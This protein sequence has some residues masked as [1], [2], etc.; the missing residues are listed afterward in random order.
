MFATPGRGLQVIQAVAAIVEL[1]GV[2]ELAP[3]D[4]LA[5]VARDDDRSRLHPFLGVFKHPCRESGDSVGSAYCAETAGSHYGPLSAVGCEGSRSFHVCAQSQ[6]HRPVS[7]VRVLA[8]IPYCHHVQKRK[9]T[10][11]VLGEI[12]GAQQRDQDQALSA[13]RKLTDSIYEGVD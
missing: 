5:G 2:V 4:A 1:D 9:R 12:F 10:R 11:G 13:C 3:D 7:E 8:A 6:T